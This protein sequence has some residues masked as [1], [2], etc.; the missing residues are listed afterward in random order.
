LGK[1]WGTKHRGLTYSIYGDGNS[2][3]G[4]YFSAIEDDTHPWTTAQLFLNSNG[5]VGI[6]KN[7]PVYRLELPNN[8]DITGRGRANA[9]YTYSDR[10][11]KDDIRDL[12]YGIE[13]IMQLKPHQYRQYSSEFKDGHLILNKEESEETIGFIAQELYKVVPETVYKPSDESSDLWSIDYQKII[14]VLVKAIQEQQQRIDSLEAKI[15]F[16]L[17]KNK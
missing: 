1:R 6:G 4:A 11:I 7:S 10:R 8:A 12:P 17:Q 16:L 5:N 13:T 2:L 15:N 9:W 3:I 14:P